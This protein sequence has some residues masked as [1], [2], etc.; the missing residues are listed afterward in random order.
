M[1]ESPLMI[2]SKEFSL[3]VIK[4]CKKLRSARL[5]MTRENTLLS[6]L[7]QFD[8]SAQQFCKDTNG[9]FCEITSTYKDGEEPHHLRYRFAKIYYNTIVVQFTYTSHSPLNVVNSVLSCSVFLDKQE[10]SPEIPLPLATDYADM[11]VFAPMYIPFITNDSGM[12]QAFASIG[13]VLQ[14]SLD[15]FADI[16][17][18]PERKQ[19]LLSAFADE[20]SHIFDV[21]GTGELYRENTDAF[22][23]WFLLRFCSAAFLNYIKGNTAKTIKQ[24]KKTKKL[25]GYETRLLVHLSADPAIERPNLSAL[26]PGLDLYNDNGTQKVNGKEFG[27]LFL[28]WILLTP[29]TAAVFVGIFFLLVSIEGRNSVYLMG[30]LYNFPFCIVF[31]F[32]TSIAI[33]YFT[34]FAFYKWLHKRDYDTYCKMDHIQNGGSEDKLMKRFLLFLTVVGVVGCVFLAKWNINFLSDGF[35]DN[36]K[37]LSLKGNYYAYSDV[38]HVYY[39]ADRVNA[40][41]ET[42]ELPSYVLVLK[43]GEEIDLYEHGDIA[44]Y[45]TPLLELFRE[46]GIPLDIP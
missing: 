5:P 37:F 35:V 31:G 4:V 25:T 13:A 36:S 12:R 11:D 29:L 43:N 40:F 44:D 2:K 7:E 38:E 24:L 3:A 19:A 33:S 9:L 8:H 39:R 22:A 32:V 41:N 23:D 21:D 18:H 45:E 28:S 42:L 20:I 34:R 6:I 30:P 46:N 27:A 10:H 1:L 16:A 26:T 15:M 17:Y 14:T